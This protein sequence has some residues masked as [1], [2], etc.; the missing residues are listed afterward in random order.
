MTWFK[1][2]VKLLIL[3]LAVVSVAT[4]QDTQAF[5]LQALNDFFTFVSNDWIAWDPVE[6][7]LWSDNWNP[8]N[9]GYCSSI[10]KFGAW[11]SW[12]SQ[13]CWATPVDLG[14]KSWNK[15]YAFR[16]NSCNSDWDCYKYWISNVSYSKYASNYE[17]KYYD[18]TQKWL[19]SVITDNKT[20]YTYDWKSYDSVLFW[21]STLIFWNTT[22]NETL[23]YLPW[24]QIIKNWIIFADPFTTTWQNVWL[25]K[26][27]TNQAWSVAKSSIEAWNIMLWNT[28]IDPNTY[29]W[30][31]SNSKYYNLFRTGAYFWP[32]RSEFL[33]N[34]SDDILWS[35]YTHT[36]W[37]VYSESSNV[38]FPWDIIDLTNTNYLNTELVGFYNQ[39]VNKGENLRK[40]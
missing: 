35:S 11:S 31:W 32:T 8:N 40:L 2:S 15:W 13:N 38:V 12:S 26:F 33:Y 30:N 14:Y 1:N 27:D 5:S 39:C 23:Q 20:T 22:T 34:Q 17:F 6:Q 7:Y 37:F 24:G 16:M 19:I 3:W 10:S 29:F 36:D 4:T 18:D 9:N 28:V 25:I 21:H